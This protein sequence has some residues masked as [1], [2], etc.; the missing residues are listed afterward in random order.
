MTSAE[1]QSDIVIIGTGF[2]GLGAA[3]RLKQEG[4]EDFIVL[5]RATDV[6]G[7][8]RDN[9]YPGCVCDVQSHLYSLSFALNPD[10]SR[11]FSPQPEIWAYLKRCAEEFDLLPHI[12]FGHSVREATWDASRG[13]WRIETTAGAFSARVLVMA[14]GGLSDPVIPHLPGIEGF[15]GRQFHSAQ[16]DQAFDLTGKRVAVIGTGA[17]AIQ[18]IPKIQPAVKALHVFQRTAPWVMQQYDGV[19]G[20]RSRALYR[21][22]PILQRAMRGVIYATRELMVF[23]F[24]HPAA[25]R[26]AQRRALKHLENAVADPAMRAKLT[27]DFTMGCKR[28]LISNDY[29]PAITQ[30]NVELVT[31]GVAEVREQSIVGGDGVERPVDAII[32]GTGFHVTDPPLAPHVHGRGGQTLAQAWA[33]SPKAYL[34]TTV[35]GFPNLFMLLGPNTGLGHSSVVYMIEVHLDHLIRA[36]RYMEANGVRAV[37]PTAEAQAEFVR[38]VDARMRGT[39]WTSGGCASWYLDA[40]GRNSTLW[41]D[42]TWRFRRRAAPF[43]PSAYASS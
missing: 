31:A 11:S 38:E 15:E 36:L 40:T 1:R 39:V 8:W 7:T 29:F 3:I 14:T 6:G 34:G 37:E 20:A 32:F 28:V 41:P 42:F 24:R 2:G 23:L 27:P 17:S 43:D 35:A 18:F 22:F 16:W 9:Q 12:R 26:I 21:R 4:I 25:M 10:W 13:C 33:G 30:P 5:E 19:H